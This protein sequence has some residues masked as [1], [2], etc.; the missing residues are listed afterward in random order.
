M[1]R[2]PERLKKELEEELQ[3][4]GEDLRSH[5][6]YHGRIPRQVPAPSSCQR[7][8][9]FS[10]AESPAGPPS[11]TRSEA[12]PAWPETNTVPWRP[13]T[14]LGPVSQ[15]TLGRT[16]VGNPQCTSMWPGCGRREGRCSVA[17]RARVS[18]RQ[19]VWVQGDKPTRPGAGLWFRSLN[20]WPAAGCLR[21]F[22]TCF[23]FK[24]ERVSS[25][26]MAARPLVP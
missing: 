14:E 25:G 3:L 8:Q 10:S 2:T 15:E 19:W 11:N 18:S 12:A 16:K 23:S 17:R 7:A 5:A 13:V 20:S 22:G 4:S 6:W 1:D 24:A 21:P 26:P 9:Q